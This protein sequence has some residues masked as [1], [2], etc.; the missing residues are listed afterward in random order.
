MWT[1][2]FKNFGFDF[3]HHPCV[4]ALLVRH[5]APNK[6]LFTLLHLLHCDCSCVACHLYAAQVQEHFPQ[7]TMVSVCGYIRQKLSNSVKIQK[8][9]SARAATS[10]WISSRPGA[11]LSVLYSGQWTR[12][13]IIM[14]VRNISQWK[15]YFLMLTFAMSL[16]LL[17]D[18]VY[19][20]LYCH[21]LIFMCFL[22]YTHGCRRHCQAGFFFPSP[23]PSH[24]ALPSPL[25]TL[26]QLG[27]L[28]ST[29]MYVLHNYLLVTILVLFV[30]TN[31]F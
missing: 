29:D 20:R 31:I 1:L 13:L 22:W 8:S 12:L 16:L 27:R 14:I 2:L 5:L 3:A 15:T 21:Y 9:R 23:F 10:S 18:H 24:L 19:H 26:N 17:K 6:I 4:I 25:P 28:W 7:E 30:W 11:V